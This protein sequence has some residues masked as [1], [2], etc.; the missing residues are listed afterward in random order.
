MIQNGSEQFQRPQRPWCLPLAE[1]GAY[2][3]GKE[4]VKVAPARC[5]LEASAVD[6]FNLDALLYCRIFFVLVRVWEGN[7]NDNNQVIGFWRGYA[8]SK[9]ILQQPE[10]VQHFL[11]YCIVSSLA[12]K[13]SQRI[14]D[15]GDLLERMGA[16]DSDSISNPCMP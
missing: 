16:P 6:L 12:G 1:F 3:G 15:Q 13:A 7:S 11:L 2:A 9:P 8:S 5:I 10:G 4:A 14:T